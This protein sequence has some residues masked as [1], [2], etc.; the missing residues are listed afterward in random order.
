METVHLGPLPRRPERDF[1]S[2][3]QIIR[4]YLDKP[5]ESAGEQTIMFRRAFDRAH[6]SRTRKY[7]Y[8]I[9][10]TAVL[11]LVAGSVILYQKNKLEKMRSTA[12][13][14]FYTMKNQELQIAQL[15]DL[16]LL[17][18]N[19]QQVAELQAKRAKFKGLEQ[20]YDAF[21]RELG[22]YRKLSD[23]DKVIMRM[24]RVFGECEVA[25]P[26]GFADEVKR[27]IGIWKS[28]DRLKVALA[29]AQE[30]GYT[31]I[32][33]R[34]LSDNN[35]PPQYFF[36]ALQESNFD[37]KA[38]GPPTR[39][40]CAKGMWQFIS[41]TADRYGLRIGPLFDQGVYDPQDERH[42]FIK[43]TVAAIKYIKELNSTNA[44]ASG[45]LVL[46]SYNW[47]EGHVR[48][49]ISRM[50]ENPR[51]RNFWRLLSMKEIPKETYDYV[52]LIFSAAV[53]CENPKL[54][55]FDCACPAST[56]IP[57]PAS[58]SASAHLPTPESAQPPHTRP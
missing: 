43:A 54:F 29:K 8:L 39:Y 14:I 16:V 17:Q 42:D 5:E 50:P 40:G 24:A 53:I 4:H 26:P 6:K 20:D 56:T 52:F 10:F 21:V 9:A 23:E 12:Q 13:N 34:I 15:E 48:E 36:L 22:I 49:I 19:P 28:S 33:T 58:A 38:V 30:K 27:Y 25:M 45:L 18:A 46:A 44:Q 55:G 47:G 51:E 41:Q 1:S 31:P 32:I 37:E 2:E 35:L 3:T 57:V 11:L 7:R